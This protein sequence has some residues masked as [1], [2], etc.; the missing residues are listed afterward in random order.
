[1]TKDNNDVT[2]DVGNMIT[3]EWDNKKS[4]IVSRLKYRGRRFGL[5]KGKEYKLVEFKN[6]DGKKSMHPYLGED[7]ENI[8][9]AL[10]KPQGSVATKNE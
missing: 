6:E 3:S 10:L 8:L 5:V 7:A 9:D 4:I 2:L 1:M